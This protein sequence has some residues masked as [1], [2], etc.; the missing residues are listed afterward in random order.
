MS[1]SDIN[2][3]NPYRLY[4]Y[5]IKEEKLNGYILPNKYKILHICGDLYSVI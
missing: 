2:V 5:V 3:T 4:F 1:S